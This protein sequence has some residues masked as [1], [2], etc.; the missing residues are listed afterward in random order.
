MGIGGNPWIVDS[1]GR[2]MDF[3]PGGLMFMFL[4][5]PMAH[6]VHEMG[7]NLKILGHLG[8]GNIILNFCYY[9]VYNGL[10]EL[11]RTFIFGLLK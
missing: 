2:S 3:D 11:D 10:M 9:V 4:N 1:H 8:F 6:N 7:Q 5:F